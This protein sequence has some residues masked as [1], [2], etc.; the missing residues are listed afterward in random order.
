M[1]LFLKKMVYNTRIFDKKNSRIFVAPRAIAQKTT[2]LLHYY[3]PNMSS[4][5]PRSRNWMGVIYHPEDITHHH[6][7][8][9]K[10]TLTDFLESGNQL[11]Y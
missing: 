7:F 10:Q 6:G 11:L 5:P 9:A 3:V 4:R 8:N 2:S 1:T